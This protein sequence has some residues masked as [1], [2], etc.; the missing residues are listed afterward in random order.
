MNV[1]PLKRY[2]YDDWLR[3]AAQNNAL[4]QERFHSI[5]PANEVCNLWNDLFART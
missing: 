5:W 3:I 1:V 4:R 2:A